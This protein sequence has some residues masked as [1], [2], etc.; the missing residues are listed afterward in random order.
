[1]RLV[2][3]LL[4]HAP[5]TREAAEVLV[6]IAEVELG[7]DGRVEPLARHEL[8]ARVRETAGGHQRARVLPQRLGGRLGVGGLR[9]RGAARKQQDHERAHQN[10]VANPTDTKTK[11]PVG[12]IMKL[13]LDDLYFAV[14]AL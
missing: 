13:R 14:P 1:M 3:G 2:G 8:G 9:A 5:R 7:A 10:T 6:A 4:E 11:S 12:R